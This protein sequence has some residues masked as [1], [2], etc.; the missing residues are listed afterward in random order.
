MVDE[1]ALMGMQHQNLRVRP[2]GLDIAVSLVTAITSGGSPKRSA[3][4]FLKVFEDV[5]AQ[6]PIRS[7]EDLPLASP[8]GCSLDLPG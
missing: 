3:P 1:F 5:I 8:L 7:L 4:D 2:F 6:N